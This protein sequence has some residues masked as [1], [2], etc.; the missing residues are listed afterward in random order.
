MPSFFDTRIEFLK[1][2]GPQKA[3]LINTELG[4][5][6][7]ADLIQHYPFRYEDRTKFQSIN[8]L[9][10]DTPFVQIKGRV[11]KI[12]TIGQMR[13]KRFVAT[14]EDGTGEV[15]LVWF[16]GIPWVSKKIKLGVDYVVFGK[17]TVFGR[18]VNFAHPEI[19][20]L[21]TQNEKT[22]NRSWL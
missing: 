21:T 13:K 22:Q 7:Y 1:G 4:L 17:P 15:E 18:K 2:V 12:E 6:T 19:E 20:V 9:N 8:S 11:K 10:G 14:F 3:A 16:K 5:F